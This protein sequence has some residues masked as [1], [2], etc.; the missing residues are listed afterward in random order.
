[1]VRAHHPGLTISPP[2]EFSRIRP[3]FSALCD[4]RIRSFCKRKS[5]ISGI[6]QADRHWH[7]ACKVVGNETEEPMTTVTKLRSSSKKMASEK[8]LSAITEPKEKK[9]C[10]GGSGS[11]E[12]CRHKEKKE[13]ARKKKKPMYKLRSWQGAFKAT[14]EY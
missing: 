9:K 1:M 7:A 3:A 8:R 2:S 13:L 6:E 10:S 4:E 11:C 12:T 14:P 5:E